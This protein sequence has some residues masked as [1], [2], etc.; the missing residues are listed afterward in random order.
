MYAILNQ[1]PGTWSGR[2]VN[3]G[4]YKDGKLFMVEP[5]VGVGNYAE[6]S[7]SNKLYFAVVVHSEQS[8]FIT[9][10][11][12]FVPLFS[13]QEAPVAPNMLQ[14]TVLEAQV[15]QLKEVDL[16][17]FPNGVTVTLTQDKI[18]QSFDFK[19]KAHN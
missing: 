14:P 11:K 17:K 16:T 5:G 18:T 19:T 3:V 1:K 2:I 10:G 15:S 7:V 8:D 12:M 13:M 9:S 6:L 4:L